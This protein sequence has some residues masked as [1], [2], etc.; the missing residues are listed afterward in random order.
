MCVHRRGSK[1][2]LKRRRVMERVHIA[3]RSVGEGRLVIQTVQSEREREEN[4]MFEW[5]EDE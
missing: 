5:E 3:A 4:D 1:P 2:L